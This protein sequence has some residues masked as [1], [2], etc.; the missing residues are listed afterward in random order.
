MISFCAPKCIEI[1][2]GCLERVGELARSVGGR[3]ILV[4]LDNF[5]ASRQIGLTDRIG[6]IINRTGLEF[7]IYS[8][9]VGEPTSDNVSEGAEIA[10]LSESD[11]VLA[12][13]GGST[14]DAA[15]AIAVKAVNPTL[16][17][18]DIP[19][20]ARLS[21]LPL[22]AVPTTAGTG[23]EGTRVCVI[24]NI[25]SGV[26]ENPSHPGLT[27][28]IAVLDPDLMKTLPKIVTAF[29]GMDALTHAIEAYVSNKGNELTNL[30]AIEAVKIISRSL[31]KV[32]GEGSNTE[33]RQNMAL[34]S[35][36]AGIAFS[37]S[38][39]NLAHAAGRSL[40]AY[41]HVPHGLS[42]SLFLPFVMEF[43]L[44][45]AEERYASIAVALGVNPAGTKRGLAQKAI[46]I[47][48]GYNDKFCIWAEA[49]NKYISDIS[50]YRRV[51]PDMV[52]S[53]MAGNGIMTNL[54][55]PSEQDAFMIFD[56]L[57]AKL[58]DM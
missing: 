29:T 42:V 17:L 56:R 50:E 31:P 57:A 7:T 9:I 47:I 25:V 27:P 53:T 16:V 11:C 10:I 37:N 39:T 3:K 28:D 49:K 15:K 1:G 22:I 18:S 33:E 38:S 6:N 54:K 46:E 26:K 32:M 43:G 23:S 41:L 20:L 30:Y 13:G 14:I 34:A 44:D 2:S 35:C 19:K 40:G 36:F 52:R 48:A 8:N 5:L 24:T 21:R 51:V 45:A 4:V 58:M 55:V 12:I